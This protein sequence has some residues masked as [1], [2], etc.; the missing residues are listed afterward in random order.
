MILVLGFAKQNRPMRANGGANR[1]H[2]LRT[3]GFIWLGAATLAWLVVPTQRFC[4]STLVLTA[5]GTECP[6]AAGRELLLAHT[7]AP[8]RVLVLLLT[9]LAA[10]C[11]S[12]LVRRT[13]FRT[14]LIALGIVAP[15][16]AGVAVAVTID[17]GMVALLFAAWRGD[18][19]G[20]TAP[21]SDNRG[22]APSSA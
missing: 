17:V 8:L 5:H 9:P 7:D 6:A 13:I 1:S 20:P 22:R 11:L 3:A 19:L 2:R 16:A 14:A 18:D 10:A 12:M 21:R 4:I 15:V